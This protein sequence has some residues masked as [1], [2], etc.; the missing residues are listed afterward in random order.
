MRYI[1]D[2]VNVKNDD[3][4]GLAFVYMESISLCIGKQPDLIRNANINNINEYCEI[5]L[6]ISRVHNFSYIWFMFSVPVDA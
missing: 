2:V 4:A 1:F 3:I 5:E 6:C